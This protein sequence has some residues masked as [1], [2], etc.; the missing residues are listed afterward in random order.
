M[1]MQWIPCSERLPEDFKKVLVTLKNKTVSTAW[2]SSSIN[3]WRN[4][5]NKG[6][7]KTV[8]AWMPFPEP[9]DE[10]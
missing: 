3:R 2:Y 4:N 7:L 10:E 9:C 1:D 6:Y 8:I 5:T